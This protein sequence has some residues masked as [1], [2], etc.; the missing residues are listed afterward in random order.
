MP[1]RSKTELISG[2][3]AEGGFPSV[4]VGCFFEPN[5]RVRIDMTTLAGAV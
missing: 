1:Y 3:L 2:L 4:I 5:S